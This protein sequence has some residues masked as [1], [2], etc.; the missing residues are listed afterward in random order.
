MTALGNEE[1][2]RVARQTLLPGLGVSGQEALHNAHVLVIGAGGLG[3]PVMQSLAA[4]G[5]GEITVIDDDIV[6]FTNIHRQILFGADDVGRPKVDAAA[7]RLAQHQPGIVVNTINDRFTATNAIDLLAHVDLLIDGSDTFNTKFLAA[8]AA[9]ATGTPLVWGTVLQY[10]GDVALWWSGHQGNR[11][12]GLRD[13]YPTQPDPANA[14]DCATAGVLGVTTSVVGNLMATEAIK[15]I[16]GLSAG[17]QAGSLL[18]YNALTA[19]VRHFQ[20]EA[21]PARPLV[22]E[23]FDDTPTANHVPMSDKGLLSSVQRGEAIA[24]DVREVGEKALSDLALPAD[25]VVHLPMSEWENDHA[26]VEDALRTLSTSTAVVYCASGR[27]SR[28]FVDKF[29][30]LA[31]RHEIVLLSLPGGV[32]AHGDAR[33]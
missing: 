18:M 3:C 10:R 12:V 27:R 17:P 5:V 29:E 25:S 14:P 7:E 28:M 9:E 19:D 4:T 21:D 1:L 13:L 26:L 23:L 22:T 24:I 11:G 2:R 32:N 8:D 16:T 31:R 6:D 30:Q 20:V 33:K 15:F